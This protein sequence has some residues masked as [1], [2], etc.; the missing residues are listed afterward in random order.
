MHLVNTAIL[1]RIDADLNV[2]GTID[3]EVK[4]RWYATGLSLFYDPVYEPCKAW[5]SSMGRNKYLTPQY[6]AL[7][8]SG[9]HDL[10]VTWF[11]D[12]IDFYHPVSMTAIEGILGTTEADC[13]TS[14]V[15]GYIIDALNRLIDG[16][17]M[18]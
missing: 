1:E 9:Q 3:P 18:Q 2:T 4:Q 6:A 17:F 11:C 12:N 14:R 5:I 7:E 8:D 15:D 16:T 10:A 13:T